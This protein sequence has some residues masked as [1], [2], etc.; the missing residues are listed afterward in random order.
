MSGCVGAGIKRV[1]DDKALSQSAIARRT[2]FSTQQFSDM[3]NGR[4]IIR[5]DYMPRIAKALGVSI[6]D[7]YAAGAEEVKGE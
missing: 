3:L 5:A 7:I 6:A 4:K 2:G 1:I